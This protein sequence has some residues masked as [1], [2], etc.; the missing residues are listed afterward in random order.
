MQGWELEGR[1]VQQM[2]ANGIEQ[3]VQK[4]RSRWFVSVEQRMEGII[5]CQNGAFKQ[6]YYNVTVM[7]RTLVLTRQ[8]CILAK[9]W[10]LFKLLQ[11]FPWYP[12]TGQLHQTSFDDICFDIVENFPRCQSQICQQQDLDL[13]KAKKNFQ[14]HLIY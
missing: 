11:M 1:C 14:G 4:S 2:E 3:E 7:K 13:Q 9:V 10:T 8:S 6:G 12:K 5:R